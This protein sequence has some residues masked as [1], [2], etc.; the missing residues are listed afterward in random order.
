[1]S[2]ITTN[3]TN[4]PTTGRVP[5]AL[6]SGFR[7]SEAA[8]QSPAARKLADQVELSDRARLLSKLRETPEIRQELVDRVRS[9]IAEGSYLT[10]DKLD[11]ATDN[12]LTDLDTFG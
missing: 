1:M 6:Q 10:S 2:D 11:A 4:S 7:T 5:T 9:E 12:L 3:I 8:S